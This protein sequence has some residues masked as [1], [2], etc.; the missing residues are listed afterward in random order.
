MNNNKFDNE[1]LN[2]INEIMIEN[3]S[4]NFIDIINKSVRIVSNNKI[5]DANQISS[6]KLVKGLKKY[7]VQLQN[8]N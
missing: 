5:T 8:G 1:V 3:P 4:L 6:K 7:K 2:E